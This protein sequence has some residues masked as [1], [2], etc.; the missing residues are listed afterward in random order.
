MFSLLM[1]DPLG[2]Q[3]VR[4]I[5]FSKFLLSVCLA[6]LSLCCPVLNDLSRVY[7]ASCL[8]TSGD[9]LLQKIEGYG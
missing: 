4:L 3:A 2:A 1:R 8:M 6:C 5:G 7:V 9:K